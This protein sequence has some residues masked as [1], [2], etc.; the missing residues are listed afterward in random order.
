MTH[1]QT[2]PDAAELGHPP[3][4]TVAQTTAI[5]PDPKRWLVLAVIAVCQLMIVLDASIVNIALPKAQHALNISNANRQWVVTAYTLGFGGLLLLGGRIA[6][7]LG[8]KRIFVIGLIGFAAASALGGLAPN[9]ATLFGARGL[10]GAFAAIMAPAALSLLAVTFT[11]AK[12]RAT[13]FS[14]Y[15]GI[16]GGGAAI[17]LVIGG[18]LTQYASW[19]WCLLVNTP[20]ALITAFFALRL[21]KESKTES[22]GHYDIPGALSVTLGL[23]SLVYGF[24]KADTDGWGSGTT[25]AFLIVAVALLAAFI[26]IELRSKKP[27]L[28]MWVVL[29]RNRGGSFLV[30]LLF[31]AGLF[32]MFLF[33][34]YY[35]QGTLHYSPLKAGFAYLPFSAGI[36]IGAGVTAQLLPRIGPRN[37]MVPGLLMAAVG[38]LWFTQIGVSSSYVVH[39]LPAELITSIGM[40]LAFVTVSSTALVGV[41]PADAGVAS[42]LINTSQQIGGSLGTA[43][44]NTIAATATT[45]Y[46][47]THRHAMAASLVHGYRVAFL[48]SAILLVIGMF[49]AALLIRAGRDDLPAADAAVPVG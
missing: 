37:I 30:A 3:T 38:L 47:T 19:R 33:L 27:L 44:L 29:N 24:T 35:L 17:G 39:I 20:V 46:L 32:G 34:T 6:D 36:V 15:G 12:E 5:E 49:S 31:S 13:A 26:G 45:T 25:I 8:R 1:A 7:Y 11:E 18:V 23:V 48:V 4:A 43:L 21:V 14:V 22:D 2:A 9:S 41:D 40:G 10:Q 16:S 28:P 42:A